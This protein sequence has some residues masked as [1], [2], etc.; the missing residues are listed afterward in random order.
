MNCV[1]TSWGK[2]SFQKISFLENAGLL[3]NER[4]KN[5]NNF[6]SKIFP[7]K[8]P[9]KTPLSEP[10]PYPVFVTPK[11]TKQWINKSSIKN[12]NQDLYKAKKTR[13]KKIVTHVND[14]LIYLRNTI[15]REEIPKNE[16]L[17]KWI[18]IVEKIL[19][20][21]KQQKGKGLKILNSK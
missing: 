14:V 18:D 3:L 4:E 10:T 16:I 2:L 6:K 15:K 8:N 1:Y 12:Q 9:D 21:N 5:I 11:L 19:N 7:T 20:F 17:D 13:N